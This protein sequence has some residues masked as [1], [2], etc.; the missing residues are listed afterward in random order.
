M[1][2]SLVCTVALGK[3][4]LV[5]WR[6]KEN[7][8]IHMTAAGAATV[9]VATTTAPL[10]MIKTRMQLQTSGSSAGGFSFP[11]YAPGR[12]AIDPAL[13]H[14][15]F[16]DSEDPPAPPSSP[17]PPRLRY[18]NSW[19]CFT[20][21]VRKEGVLALYRGLSASYLGGFETAIQ[22]VIYEQLKSM[23]APVHAERAGQF[24]NVQRTRPRH[25]AHRLGPP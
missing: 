17:S 24:S 25:P 2:S 7:W 12:R 3:D 15:S 8:Q 19:H 23:R 14:I 10:W 18:R 5:R 9:A 16:W 4:T 6:Q 13:G 22:F 21:V 11:V 20:E 1:P